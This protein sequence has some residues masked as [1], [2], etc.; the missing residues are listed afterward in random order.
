MSSVLPRKLRFAF[1][2]ED[3]HPDLLGKGIEAAVHGGATVI[4]VVATAPFGSPAL[5]RGVALAN[6]CGALV[7][8]S[9]VTVRS[10]H[11]D[12][13]YRPRC[14]AS[15]RSWPSARTAHHPAYTVG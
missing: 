9:A 13:A 7:I 14:P 2:A 4:A 12:I 10:Q 5:Q 3:V 1:Q 6:R 11:G 15:S 8:A